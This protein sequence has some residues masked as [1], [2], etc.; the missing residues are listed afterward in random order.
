MKLKTRDELLESIMVSLAPPP[1]VA[2]RF[3]DDLTT[4]TVEGA[5][6]DGLQS[7][8]CIYDSGSGRCDGAYKHKGK[9]HYRV[10]TDGTVGEAWESPW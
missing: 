5:Q 4:P 7:V 3:A 2:Q 6:L 8:G 9:I 10:V 1:I